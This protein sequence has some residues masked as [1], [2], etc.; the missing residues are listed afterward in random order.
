MAFS[1]SADHLQT[2]GN[3]IDEAL[4]LIGVLEEGES[5]STDQQTSGLRSLN[6]IVK[7][8]S[9]DSIIYSQNEYQLDLVASTNTYTLGVSNV[10][11]IPQKVLN[12]TLIDTSTNDEIPLNPLTQ[13]EWYALTDKTTEARPTQYYQKRNPVG[14]DMDLYLWPTPSDTTYD[15]KLWLQYPLR[16]TDTISQDVYFTQEWYLAL[17]FQLA[18]VLS[19]KYGIPV[20]ERTAL[21]AA[22]KEFREEAESYDTD[23]SMFIQPRSEHG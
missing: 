20:M 14:V 15:M 21:K 4:E 5:A 6:N 19:F 22:A 1:T 9:A 16:D 2:A 23:G 7:L 8:W 18:Y 17:S 11:Y 10:G 3:M 12:A 13:E